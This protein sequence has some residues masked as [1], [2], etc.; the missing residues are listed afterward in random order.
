MI[1]IGSKFEVL[2]SLSFILHN[3]VRCLRPMPVWPFRFVC[4]CSFRDL[5]IFHLNQKTEMNHPLFQNFEKRFE[6]QKHQRM[7][8]RRQLRMRNRLLLRMFR[9]LLIENR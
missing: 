4:W 9:V 2:N 8:P 3:A 5:Q 6:L 1:L 7:Q